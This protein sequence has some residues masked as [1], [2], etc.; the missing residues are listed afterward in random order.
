M[1]AVMRT[2]REMEE[3]QEPAGEHDGQPRAGRELRENGPLLARLT[4]DV[5]LRVHTGDL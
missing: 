1:T 2:I 3:V 4:N 5:C